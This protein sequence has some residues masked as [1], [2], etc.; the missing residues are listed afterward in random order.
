MTAAT[1]DRATD[2][3]DGRRVHDLLAAS[4]T[5]YAGTM[6]MLDA[7]GNAVP[8][9]AQSGATTLTVRAVALKRAST[10]AGDEG[11]AGGIGV[12]QFEN[13]ASSDEI[14]REEIGATCYAVDDNTVAKTSDSSKRPAAGV[15]FDVDDA[16]VWVRIGA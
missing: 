13:S 11:V 14:T 6:Y 16:G 12:Y 5:I 10:A 4:T 9:V 3:R 2:E 1:K 15:I 7:S 8:A